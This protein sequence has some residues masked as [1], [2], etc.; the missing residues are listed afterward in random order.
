MASG[1]TCKRCGGKHW[2]EGDCPTC[3]ARQHKKSSFLKTVDKL[4]KGQDSRKVHD[5][6]G[7]NT[8]GRTKH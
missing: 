8:Q 5:T 2:A 1:N 3:R 6:K 4:S 7:R